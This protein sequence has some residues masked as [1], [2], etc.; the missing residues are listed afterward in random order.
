[1]NL[2]RSLKK[3]G[4][5]NQRIW[6]RLYNDLA[7]TFSHST[8]YLESFINLKTGLEEDFR[9]YVVSKYN[10]MSNYLKS[11]IDRMWKKYFGVDFFRE[12]SQAQVLDNLKRNKR[13][14]TKKA[15]KYQKGDVVVSLSRNSGKYTYG[16]VLNFGEWDKG[17]GDYSY[18]ILWEDG[19]TSPYYEEDLLDD[20]P[21]TEHIKRHQILEDENGDL[22]KVE[23]VK[24]D[25]ITVVKQYETYDQIDIKDLSGLIPYDPSN[26]IHQPKFKVGDM[27]KILDSDDYKNKPARITEYDP[28]YI[29][30][31]PYCV[32]FLNN[33]DGST[34]MSESRL[35]KTDGEF[36]NFDN[37]DGEEEILNLQDI[38]NNEKV[39]EHN[40][41]SGDMVIC[42]D[43]DD[44]ESVLTIGKVYKV[45]N[46]ND[47]FIRIKNDKGNHTGYYFYRFVKYDKPKSPKYKA[48][49]VLI[50]H[51]DEYFNKPIAKYEIKGINSNNHYIYDIY[52]M[53]NDGWELV[54][55]GNEWSVSKIDNAKNI[56]LQE[57]PT[58][59]PKYNE[60]TVFYSPKGNSQAQI[61]SVNDDH[62]HVIYYD[63]IDGKWEK[64]MEDH[65]VKAELF[66]NHI[67]EWDWKNAADIKI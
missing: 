63:K 10:N 59:I 60:G 28:S 58:Y 8:E 30:D 20:V 43:N 39:E 41:N 15:P 23:K 48:G 50:E 67:K 46:H 14:R 38:I 65:N 51:E 45:Y 22:Y 47:E 13:R 3:A 29:F 4:I 1:M 33:Y 61:I 35:E 19:H 34:W 32:E 55:K 11:D 9:E 40:I 26:S 44:R 62:Y 31:R 21:K 49:D 17:I 27:V 7:K 5:D 18:N 24:D 37:G 54:G 56:V 53:N 6:R 12:F 66:D 64:N 42:I 36:N 2:R 52:E 57:E 16:T 25:Y